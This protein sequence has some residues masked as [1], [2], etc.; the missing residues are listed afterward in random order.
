MSAEDDAAKQPD[1]LKSL[2]KQ[3]PGQLSLVGEQRLHDAIAA[4]SANVDDINERLDR[5]ATA[6]EMVRDQQQWVTNAA[7]AQLAKVSEAISGGGVRGLF[8]VASDTLKDL[9]NAQKMPIPANVTA[10][11]SEENN[12][13]VG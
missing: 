1:T 9:R 11:D 8:R 2:A 3:R 13:H 6:V 10:D 12:D 5:L 7:N 4:L